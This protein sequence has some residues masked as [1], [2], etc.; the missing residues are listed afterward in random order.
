MIEISK[1]A[2][3]SISFTATEYPDYTGKKN[4]TLEITCLGD[5]DTERLTLVFK[6]PETYTDFLRLLTRDLIARPTWEDMCNRNIS[7]SS[8]FTVG[9]SDQLPT[10]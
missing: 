1:I 8:T 7:Q 3:G 10:L 6:T 4:V 5:N 2:T 9:D